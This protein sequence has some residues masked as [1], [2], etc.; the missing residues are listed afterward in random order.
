MYTAEEAL[1][2]ARFTSLTFLKI[3]L[4]VFVSLKGRRKR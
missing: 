1:N 3:Y 4:P 2:H